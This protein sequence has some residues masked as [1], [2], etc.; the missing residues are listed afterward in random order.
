MIDFKMLAIASLATLT[1]CSQ[2]ETRSVQYFEANLDEA[3]DVV[4]SC[5][6]GDMR[7]DECSNANVAVKTAEGK[8]RFERFRGNK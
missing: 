4:R 2:P 7:G 3:R 8:A 5:T 1:A 6:A